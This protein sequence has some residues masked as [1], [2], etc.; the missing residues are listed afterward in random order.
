MRQTERSRSSEQYCFVRY[1]KAIVGRNLE[2][3]SKWIEDHQLTEY[4]DSRE[5]P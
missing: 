1:M 5:S 2:E 4:F 3:A